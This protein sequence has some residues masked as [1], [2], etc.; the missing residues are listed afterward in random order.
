MPKI[1]TLEGPKLGHIAELRSQLYS[2]TPK[3]WW[4]TE[5]QLMGL[6]DPVKANPFWVVAGLLVGAWLAGSKRGQEFLGKKGGR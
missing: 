4:R 1:L 6:L 5:A 3:S 2:A